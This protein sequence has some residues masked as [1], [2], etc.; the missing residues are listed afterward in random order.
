MI[1]KIIIKRF[2]SIENLEVVC[3]DTFNVI[4]GE[5][6]IGKTTIFEA[7]HLWKMCYDL[8]VKSKKMGFYATSQNIRFK[9]ME[10]IRVYHDRDLFPQ[11]C[12]K[13]DATTEITLQL[14]YQNNL[15]SLGFRISK[16]TNMEDTYFQTSYID[17]DQ[18]MNFANMIS[19][20]PNYNLTNFIAINET[21]PIANII[22]KEPYMYKA[23]VMDKIAKGKSYEVLRNK[24]IRNLSDVQMHINNVMQ[25]DYVITEPDKDNKT[26]ISIK[27]DGKDIFSYGSG[28]LQLAEIF[29][30][31]EYLDAKIYILLIDEPD[32]HLH[33]KLQKK[34]IEEFRGIT[35]SQLFIITHNERIL[36]EASEEEILFVSSESINSGVLNHLPLGGKGIVLE[37]L[38]GCIG[39]VEQL[40]YAS[41]LILVEGQGDVDFFNAIKPKYEAYTGKELSTHVIMKMEGIDTLN[42]K[43][44]SYARALKGILPSTCKWLLIRDTDCVP[45]NRKIAAGNDDKEN[46]DTSGAAF[47]VYFQNG[48][49]IESTFV[50]EPEK[51]A[52]MLCSYYG[53]PEAE[54]VNLKRKMLD[55][56]QDFA[57]KVKDVTNVQIHQELEKHFS[58][59]KKK[60]SGRV[61]QAL[62]FRDMLAQINA[63]NI[64]YIMTKQILNKYL[65]KIHNEVVTHYEGIT[66]PKLTSQSIFPFYFSWVNCKNDIFD[67]HIEML[68][69]IYN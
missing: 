65:E 28:F 56:N 27:V 7:I 68:D 21:R 57:T 30:S 15:Y 8:N 48:Y 40:R 4:I 22:A 20:I 17:A 63:S 43:L 34:L 3:N 53:L 50:S 12:P 55:I 18:F 1:K 11:G 19:T 38:A 36:N 35:N 62:E 44:I 47:E 60:R 51:L 37:N 39:Y 54:Y 58:R 41:K 25:S 61:Y 64:Q 52:K 29:S 31:F 13:K 69:R 10:F 26:Y 23:Q 24:L 16:V 5:N 59:Q 46:V 6:N 42:A 14:E 9:D 67:S 2:K 66:I 32:S 49:G 33:V 45:V